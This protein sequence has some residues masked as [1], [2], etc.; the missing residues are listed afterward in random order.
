[1]VD[2]CADEEGEGHEGK[3]LRCRG[4]VYFAVGIENG[5]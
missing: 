1:V 2:E 5:E 4:E 3:V